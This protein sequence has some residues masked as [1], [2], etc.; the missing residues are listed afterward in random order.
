MTR[1]FLFCFVVVFAW[2]SPGAVSAAEKHLVAIDYQIPADVHVNYHLI[3]RTPCM[4]LLEKDDLVRIGT[5][6]MYRYRDGECL[7]FTSMEGKYLVNG[8]VFGVRVSALRYSFPRRVRQECINYVY[9]DTDLSYDLCSRLMYNTQVLT[10]RAPRLSDEGIQE[11]L[12]TLSCKSTKKKSKKE[13]LSTIQDQ[14]GRILILLGVLGKCIEENNK[15]QQEI[16]ELLK[17]RETQNYI[18]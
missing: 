10:L 2:F 7:A 16:I 4:I 3:G 8:E 12:N 6:I 5:E 15:V 1:S 18:S 17:G 13:L 9:L 11:L 14:Y